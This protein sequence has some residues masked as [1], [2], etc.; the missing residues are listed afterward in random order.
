[1]YLFIV[2]TSEK[3]LWGWRQLIKDVCMYSWIPQFVSDFLQRLFVVWI[4]Y[5]NII[6]IYPWVLRASCSSKCTNIHSPQGLC[7]VWMRYLQHSVI[8]P[9]VLRWAS[10]SSTLNVRINMLGYM[11][12]LS[13]L[14]WLLC[15]IFLVTCSFSVASPVSALFHR[16]PITHRDRPLREGRLYQHHV[17]S[18]NQRVAIEVW[19]FNKNTLTSSLGLTRKIQSQIS[20]WIG[21]QIYETFFTILF[22]RD[23]Y[24]SCC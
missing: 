14:Y 9:W 21:T 6:D 1:L 2:I 22:Y 11:H 13:S 4:R 7:S 3:P 18:F 20:N 15:F 24:F 19:Y 10:C 23:L 16:K 5:L 17:R 12:I 8:Y